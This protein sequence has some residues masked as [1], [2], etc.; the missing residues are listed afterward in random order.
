MKCY[1][2]IKSIDISVRKAFEKAGLLSMN[3]ERD[4]QIYEQ[5]D[6]YLRTGTAK[7]LKTACTWAE[8]ISNI[9]EFQIYRIYKRL[10]SDVNC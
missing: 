8:D 3:T 5:V 4:L 6:A 9:G 2:A 7:D 1:D 10:S